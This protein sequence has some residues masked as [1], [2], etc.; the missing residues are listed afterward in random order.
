MFE[1]WKDLRQFLTQDVENE[2]EVKMYA[3]IM[4][5]IL[6]MFS[7]YCDIAALFTAFS[8]QPF[9]C[10]Y[11]VIESG[12]AIWLISATFKQNATSI[13]GISAVMF[14]LHITV[15]SLMF[16]VNTDLMQ[17]T[18]VI[19]L[20]L[21]A[22]D[23]LSKM[24]M[25]TVWMII[26]IFY[27]MALYY[28]CDAHS[29]VYELTSISIAFWRMIHILLVSG[30]VAFIIIVATSD[31]SAM[32]KK[33]TQTNSRLRDVAGKDPLTGLANRRNTYEVLHKL[34]DDYNNGELG[35]LTMVMADVDLFKRI[36][37][38]Y[39]H[40]NGDVVLKDLANIMGAFMRDKGIASRWGGEEFVLVFRNYNGD[41]VYEMLT[42]L[43]NEIS[44][45]EYN[46]NDD[47]I[48]VTLT[49]GIAEQ[50]GASTADE[51]IK[52]AD[53]KLYLGKQKGRNIIIF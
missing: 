38:T 16:G 10:I 43:Q 47:T 21:F 34:I 41:E 44:K 18:Y 48:H 52:E 8:Q 40:D 24:W 15:H 6:L 30:S 22:V 4:R 2:N 36:N 51:T 9:I 7:T 42:K 31:F 35:A 17:Y 14:G 39:G 37:D 29:A 28:Y 12:I 32:R 49:F 50:G 26:I 13:C 27:R 33:L 23:F 25:K 53:E 19:I 11:L 46:W 5:G 3:I 20:L 45:L 1:V